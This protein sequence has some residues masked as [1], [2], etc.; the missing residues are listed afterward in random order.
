MCRSGAN[1]AVSYAQACCSNTC[2][3]IL[4]VD[5]CMSTQQNRTGSTTSDYVY[6]YST[7]TLL[8]SYLLILPTAVLLLRLLLSVYSSCHFVLSWCPDDLLLVLL[9]QLLLICPHCQSFVKHQGSPQQCVASTWNEFYR[10]P[11]CHR[12]EALS[13]YF[14]FIFNFMF[15]SASEHQVN[16]DL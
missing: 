7:T 8:S 4:T 3:L 14:E 16:K 10:H 2:Q 13:A 6:N 12:L 1:V 11:N 9:R 15:W 5:N